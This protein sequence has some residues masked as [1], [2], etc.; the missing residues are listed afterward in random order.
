MHDLIHGLSGQ[1]NTWFCIS[2][3][4][5]YKVWHYGPSFR[6]NYKIFA[7]LIQGFWNYSSHDMSLDGKRKYNVVMNSVIMVQVKLENMLVSWTSYKHFLFVDQLYTLPFKLK[8]L[9]S[10]KIHIQPSNTWWSLLSLSSWHWRHKLLEKFEFLFNVDMAALHHVCRFICCAI[11]MSISCSTKSQKV[12]WIQEN[13]PESITRQPP[14]VT[15]LD[16]DTEQ[17]GSIDSCYFCC[18]C[19]GNTLTSPVAPVSSDL[20]HQQAVSVHRTVAW[21]CV[22][23]IQAWTLETV[24]CKNP[25]RSAVFDWLRPNP[26]SNKTIISPLK[27]LGPYFFSIWFEP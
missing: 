6:Q 27:S 11:M 24:V 14:P 7:R 1:N 15:S 20:S 16:W 21:F 4:Y 3:T 23:I 18:T 9:L 19:S 5:T 22:F 13:I 26:S 2:Y 25:C 8:N 17:F 10:P 12:D